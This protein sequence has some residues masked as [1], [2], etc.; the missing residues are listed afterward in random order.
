MSTRSPLELL[1]RLKERNTEAYIKLKDGSEYR[2]I[3]EDVDRS[4]NII[5][6]EAM[7][8]NEDGTPLVKYGRV[9]I[10]GS[11][12]VYVFTREENIAL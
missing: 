4:M 2:G 10:R 6:S 5:L 3:V 11:N 7:Q 12:I 1:E 9:L 8:V